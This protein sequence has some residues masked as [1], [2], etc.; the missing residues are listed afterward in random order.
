MPSKEADRLIKYAKD[1]AQEAK[2]CA[3][4]LR[5][6]VIASYKAYGVPVSE[7]EL[8]RIEQVLVSVVLELAEGDIDSLYSHLTPYVK[9]QHLRRIEETRRAKEASQN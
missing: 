3:N 4:I 2:E 8:H 7:F 5:N 9:V 6:T 1:M